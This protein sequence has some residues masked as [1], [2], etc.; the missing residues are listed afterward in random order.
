MAKRLIS[1][2]LIV[3]ALVISVVGCTG[4]GNNSG[5]KPAQAAEETTQSAIST[6]GVVTGTTFLQ[7]ASACVEQEGMHGCAEIVVQDAFDQTIG[8]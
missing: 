1:V 6:T 8:E 5:V 2:F 7:Q 3:L 4:E